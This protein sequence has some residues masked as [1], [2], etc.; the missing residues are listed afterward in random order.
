M[1]MKDTEQIERCVTLEDDSVPSEAVIR[2]I[3]QAKGVDPLEM[4]ALYEIVDPEALDAVFNGDSL[5]YV[6]FPFR[7]YEVIVASDEQIL[8]QDCETNYE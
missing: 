1:G 6:Q 3:A 5:S 7:G 8:I 2:T 4:P